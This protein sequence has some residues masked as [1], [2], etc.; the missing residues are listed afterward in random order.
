MQIAVL[1]VKQTGAL[2]LG[3]EMALPFCELA[4][5]RLLSWLWS[6]DEGSLC[7]SG[8]KWGHDV[9][10]FYVV[11]NGGFRNEKAEQAVLSAS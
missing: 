5:S 1:G 2:G 11:L 6:N 9:W 10:W 7:D 8:G 4:Y 3:N